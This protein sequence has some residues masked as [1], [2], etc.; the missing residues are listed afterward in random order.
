MEVVIFS[1]WE[2]YLR[3]E[4]GL[5]NSKREYKEEKEG[6][7]EGKIRGRKI[8]KYE[9]KTRWKG[10]KYIYICRESGRRDKDERMTK[11]NHLAGTVMRQFIKE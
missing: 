4:E 7:K 2:I 5:G 9:K 6:H 11:G 8:E 10:N 3:Y 1:D